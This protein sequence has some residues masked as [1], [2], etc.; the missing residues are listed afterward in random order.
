MLKIAAGAAVLLASASAYAQE[1]T[2][3]QPL[4]VWDSQGHL[5]GNLA[6]QDRVALMLTGRPFALTVY[7]AGIP[8]NSEFIY[9]TPDCSGERYLDA[10]TLPITG[11]LGGGVIFYPGPLTT[12]EAKATGGYNSEGQF[13]CSPWDQGTRTVAP[14]WVSRTPTWTPP[15]CV[16]AT[17]VRC[18]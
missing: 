8:E 1:Q 14:A 17:K 16:S 12:I 15:F 4:G 11:Y 10:S 13:G 9:A 5:V 3:P 18:Q 2:Q 6:G 7:P